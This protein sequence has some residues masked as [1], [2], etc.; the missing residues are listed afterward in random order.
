MKIIG[1]G[2][3][4]TTG[5]STLARLIANK[6]EKSEIISLDYILD[7]VKRKFFSKDNLIEGCHGDGNLITLKSNPVNDLKSQKI[8]EIY[9]L[10]KNIFTTSIVQLKL[11]KLYR[12]DFELAIIE[13]VT[14]E[15]LY[16]EY[17]YLVKI[18]SPDSLRIQRRL[19]RDKIV[20]DAS[21]LHQWDE[22]DRQ[23]SRLR[24]L[25]YDRIL[26]NVL[27]LRYYDTIAGDIYKEVVRKGNK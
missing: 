8:K 15:A 20:V 7:D 23:K 5:K 2:G 19:E 25:N 1:I 22:L 27:P 16:L 17:D 11:L 10:F 4:S 26:E 3:Y 6:S 21:T 9:C 18:I 14:L 12:E 24:N 13:G